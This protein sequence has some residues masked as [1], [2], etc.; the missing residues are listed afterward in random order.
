MPWSSEHLK[1]FSDNGERLTTSDGKEIEVWEFNHAQDDVVLSAW[2]RHFRNHY[3]LDA[4]I[5]FL[6][7]KLAR[8]DY[9]NNIKFPSET[10]KLGPG[11]RAGDFGEILVCDYL[12]WLL[13]CWVPR[14]RWSSKVVRD[15]SPKGSDVVGFRFHHKNGEYS[16]DDVMFV[17]E[18]KTKFSAST[19]NRL[20]NA[21][22][23]SAKDHIR[24]DESLNFIKQ[25]LYEY[26][27]INQ[28]KKI[29][30]FQNPVDI[31]FKENY[32][33]AAI[34]SSD[35]FDVEELTSS[36]CNK[37]PTTAKSKEYTPHPHH[38]N[39]K[40]LVIRGANMM[41][42]VHELYRRAADEA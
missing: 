32:G 27:E 5:D 17:F 29:E 2:A 37:I 40:L 38:G 23:D 3:C 16:I 8:K 7:G 13:D 9:L 24:I 6:R 41:Q 26:R 42:L 12:Q 11:I 30:R 18:S 19:V 36:D 25:K 35:F 39:L 34:I 1:W 31:P 10:S 22:N 14:V 20:Q 15:E 4:D 33:A 28:A 21:I